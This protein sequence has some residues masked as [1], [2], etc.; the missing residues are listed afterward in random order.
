VPIWTEFGRTDRWPARDCGARTAAGEAGD[1]W[2]EAPR[3]LATGPDC[4]RGR[5]SYCG[6]G[7][8]Q[9]GREGT[10]RLKCEQA[11]GD[12]VRRQ[13]GS[14]QR[15]WRESRPAAMHYVQ[16]GRCGRLKIEKKRI[17]LGGAFLQFVC[18][19][20]V[21]RDTFSTRKKSIRVNLNYNLQVYGYRGLLPKP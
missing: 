18:S 15:G 12:V 3:R 17:F 11:A 5:Q 16:R 4:G 13:A 10:R 9:R 7:G 1:G 6:R 8:G 2:D 19:V 20:S 21:P 14:G